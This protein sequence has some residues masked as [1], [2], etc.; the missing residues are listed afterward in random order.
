V[1]NLERPHESIGNLTPDAYETEHRQFYY[2]V[3]AA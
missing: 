2:S 3:V 1:Y